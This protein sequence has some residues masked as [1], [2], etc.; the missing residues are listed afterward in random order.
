[1]SRM[2]HEAHVKMGIRIGQATH[3]PVRT[4]KMGKPD[5]IGLYPQTE[6]L[7]IIPGPIVD[8]RL[9]APEDTITQTR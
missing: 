3:I 6:I 4:T 7:R 8:Q 1:M 5:K 2:C 9:I